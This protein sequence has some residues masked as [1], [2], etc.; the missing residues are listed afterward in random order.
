MRSLLSFKDSPEDFNQCPIG[1]D[2]R[3]KLGGFHSELLRHCNHHPPDEDATK[4][5]EE[6]KKTSAR[7]LTWTD[8]ILAL[9]L[10]KKDAKPSAP[11]GNIP[12]QYVC[13][14]GV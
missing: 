8:K 1:T 14:E 9:V 5:L 4:E 12:G 13:G 2:L 3:K 10:G 6:A 11:N 7:Q